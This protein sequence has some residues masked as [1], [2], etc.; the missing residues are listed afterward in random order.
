MKNSRFTFY[1]TEISFENVLKEYIELYITFTLC[2][3]K[4][5]L[6]YES[7]INIMVLSTY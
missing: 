6:A 3:D 2:I 1:S 7:E 5:R 4:D